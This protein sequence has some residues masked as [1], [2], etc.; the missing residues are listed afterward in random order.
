MIL[1]N[2]EIAAWLKK[3]EL[4]AQGQPLGGRFAYPFGDLQ[5]TYALHSSTLP[6]G[7]FG[8][9]PAGLR[10]NTKDGRR[11]YLAGDTG[12]FGDMQLIGEEGIDLAVLPI[13]GHFTMDPDEA[14]RAVRMIRPR[15]VIPIH[16]STWEN[17]TQD[18]SA[19]AQ[20]VESQ[21]DARVHV[22]KPGEVWILE[23]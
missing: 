22:L 6:D 2:Q 5:L 8:G 3:K 4:K 17:I 23:S 1:S 20:R 13:G 11:L 7:S 14:L 15:H 18:A 19:W 9:S 16:F 21:T 10:I 12:L